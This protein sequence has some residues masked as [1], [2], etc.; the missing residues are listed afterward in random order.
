MESDP[1]IVVTESDGTVTSLLLPSGPAGQIR[2]NPITGLGQVVTTGD[3]AERSDQRTPQVFYTDPS[4][5]LGE[6]FYKETEGISSFTESQCDTRFPGMIVLP[7]DRTRLGA[8]GEL[9]TRKGSALSVVPWRAR[10]LGQTN[11]RWIVYT[12]NGSQ[13]F[14]YNPA[15]NTWA[16]AQSP[17]NFYTIAKFQ[18]QFLAATKGSGGAGI[19]KSTTGATGSWSA[20]ALAPADSGSLCEHDSKIFADTY[21]GSALKLTWTTD[22]TVA[23]TT[24]GGSIQLR[25]GEF[26]RQLIEWRDRVGRA[27]LYIVTTRRILQYDEDADTFLLFYDFDLFSSG[28]NLY[29]YAFASP[30]DGNLYVLLSNAASDGTAGTVVWFSG[31]TNRTSPNRRGALPIGTTGPINLGSITG[32]LQWLYAAT[33]PRSGSGTGR[34]FAMSNQQAWHTLLDGDAAASA[35]LGIGYGNDT[36]LSIH[37]DGTTYELPLP[38]VPDLPLF[39]TR[40]YRNGD[41]Y[42]HEFA[43]TDGGT[44]NMNKQWLWVTVQCLDHTSANKVPGM[45]PFGAVTVD[46]RRDVDTGW[47]TLGVLDGTFTSWP[48]VLPINSGFGVKAKQIKIRLRLFS[49]SA[50]NTPVVASV[51]LA[52]VRQEVPRSAY[53]VPID[54]SNR[55]H[56]LYLGKDVAQLLAAMDRWTQPGALVRLDFAGGD[57]AS[58]PATGRTVLNCV[59]AYSGE[60]DPML[61]PLRYQGQ[62]ADFTPPASG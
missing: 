26:V 25:D 17:T 37:K 48:V 38:D 58:V 49:G 5:G 39:A 34:V 12:D 14:V 53:T 11:A 54:L 10:Y 20:L 21:T 36:L 19:F 57:E 27:V 2:K 52:Y 47:T 23:W 61:G 41:L 3:N 43:F 59:F 50:G 51:G 56:P 30:G 29:P 28:A 62:F 13:A 22:T 40:T 7:P 15:A 6:F 45:T 42:D 9:A 44:P 16:L 31:T 4:G 32:G 35:P 18:G 46:Y 55:D 33:W 1:H 8:I 60:D 24:S